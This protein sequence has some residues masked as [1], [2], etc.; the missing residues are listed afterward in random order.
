MATKLN[1]KKPITVQGWHTDEKF[2]Y[3]SMTSM[4]KV[5]YL[6]FILKIC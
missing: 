3:G 6:S 5:N 2:S 1:S 4:S